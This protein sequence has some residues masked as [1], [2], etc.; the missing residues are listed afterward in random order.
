M[1]RLQ[2]QLRDA[3]GLL[4]IGAER[5]GLSEQEIKEVIEYGIL[6][7]FELSSNNLEPLDAEF[8]AEP[9]PANTLV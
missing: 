1:N 2:I 9:S 5:A 3:V 8:T 6:D 4:I 7:E